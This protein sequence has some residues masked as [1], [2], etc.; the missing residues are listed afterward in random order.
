MPKNNRPKE[1]NDVHPVALTSVPMKYFEKIIQKQILS[2]LPSQLDSNQFAYRS[3][4]GVDDA[5]LVMLNNIYEHLEKANSLVTIVFIDFSSM[6]NT[7]QPG[8]FG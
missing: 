6:F 1:N 4:G 5:L 3:S 2:G 7:I 8:E